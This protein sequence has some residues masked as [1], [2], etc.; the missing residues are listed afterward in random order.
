M[1]SLNDDRRPTSRTSRI[2][3]RKEKENFLFSNVLW[4]M[5][6]SCHIIFLSISIK[7]PSAK[8]TSR[9]S[10]YKKKTEVKRYR[11]QVEVT[12]NFIKSH[13]KKKKNLQ[14]RKQVKLNAIKLFFCCFRLCS[15]KTVWDTWGYYGILSLEPR[16]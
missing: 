11:Q 16:V 10:P 6:F 14:S 12:R 5:Y 15:K 2:K 4:F 8:I 3:S 13:E 9:F 1:F 7:V